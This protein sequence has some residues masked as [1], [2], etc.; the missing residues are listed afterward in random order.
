M[1]RAKVFVDGIL[2]GHLEE[3]QRGLQYRF[4]YLD[5][6]VGQPISLTMPIKQKVY[7]YDRFPP[8]FDGLLPEG[9][10]LEALLRVAKLDRNDLF[11]QL[12]RVGDDLVGNVTVQGE[13]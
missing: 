2:A 10:G 5:D 1:R 13:E 8:F 9:F 11:G 4:I 3:L 12:L 6:Y 7:E